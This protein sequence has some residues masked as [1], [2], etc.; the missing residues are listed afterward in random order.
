MGHLQG[1]CLTKSMHH[2]LPTCEKCKRLKMFCTDA[3]DCIAFVQKIEDHKK[4]ESSGK[5][6]S[7]LVNE[8]GEKGTK[9]KIIH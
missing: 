3:E 6:V 5:T 7:E 2:T 4:N 9:V 1:S 8:V